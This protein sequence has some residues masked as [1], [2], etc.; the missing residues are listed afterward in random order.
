MT[1]PIPLPQLR[2][3]QQGI[4]VRVGGHGL[5]RRRYLE[6]GLVTGETVCAERVAPL[7]DPVAYRIKG[8]TLSLRREEAEHIHVV[9]L[10]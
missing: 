2:P 8:Y 10:P 4:I 9:P 7:G 5:P 1:Q 3:G 6:L